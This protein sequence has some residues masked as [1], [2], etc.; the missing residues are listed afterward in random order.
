M[1][2]KPKTPTKG[3]MKK[4]F[5]YLDRE[6]KKFRLTQ[7]DLS[8]LYDLFYMI[9]SNETLK[10]NKMDKWADEFHQRIE[11]IVIPELYE[12]KDELKEIVKAK[13]KKI[14]REKVYK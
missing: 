10:L 14:K 5:K 8:N 6:A 3:E 9:E 12:E 11:K 7:E 2:M 4:Y 13:L 1:Q